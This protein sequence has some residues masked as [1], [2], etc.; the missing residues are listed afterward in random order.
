MKKSTETQQDII[1]KIMDLKDFWHNVQMP[2][3]AT[4]IH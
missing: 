2:E 3:S 1:R 4:F